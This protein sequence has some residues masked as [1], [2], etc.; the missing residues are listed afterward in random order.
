M[1]YLAPAVLFLCSFAAIAEEA[2]KPIEQTGPMGVVV[3]F[4]AV[5]AACVWFFISMNKAS[6]KAADDKAVEA[7]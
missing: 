3:F 7:K 5:V 6:K 2:P 1:K 4:A